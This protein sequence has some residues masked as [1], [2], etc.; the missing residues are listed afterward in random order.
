MEFLCGIPECAASAHAQSNRHRNVITSSSL[1]H[2]QQYYLHG[3]DTGS[4]LHHV[5]TYA[6]RAKRHRVA[7]NGREPIICVH[8]RLRYIHG[9]FH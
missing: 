9:E 4:Q 5:Y 1:C 2:W 3:C 7:G 6:Q 8:L